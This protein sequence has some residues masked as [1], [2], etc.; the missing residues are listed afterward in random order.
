VQA[1]VPNVYAIKKLKNKGTKPQQGAVEPLLVYV[2]IAFC[3][4]Y[5]RF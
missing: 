2:Y 5:K 4:E 3:M 1:V